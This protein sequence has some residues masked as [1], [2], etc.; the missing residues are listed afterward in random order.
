MI[1]DRFGKINF[2]MIFLAIFLCLVFFSFSDQLNQ[3]NYYFTAKAAGEY[4]INDFELD[5]TPQEHVYSATPIEFI[6]NIEYQGIPFYDFTVIYESE[7]YTSSDSPPTDA[8]EYVVSIVVNDSEPEISW[9]SSLTINPKPI[10]IEYAG[11]STYQYFGVEFSRNISPIGVID[12]EDIG[13]SYQYIGLRNELAENI[14]PVEAD[15]YEIVISISNSNYIITDYTGNDPGILL[16]TKANL[17]AKANDITINEG[18]EPDFSVA[19]TGFVNNE[20]VDDLISEPTVIFEETD[21]G[22][23]DIIPSGGA[24]DN[25]S[26]QYLEGI[27]TINKLS[28]SAISDDEL[29]DISISGVFHPDYSLIISSLSI[30]DE[31]YLEAMDIIVLRNMDTY[32][33]KP[34]YCFDTTQSQGSSSS[35]R[36]KIKISGVTLKEI[37]G[38][39]IL[40]VDNTG[41]VHEITKYNYLNGDLSFS[42]DSLG[43]IFIVERQ[44]RT[45]LTLG[46]LVGLTLVIIAFV[47]LTK[48]KYQ[49][50]K[51]DIERANQEIRD[52]KNK[53]RWD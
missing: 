40:V 13:L 53:Y 23:Y 8:A 34:I 11:T 18:E 37:F 38:Y 1:S 43:T 24:S 14:K 5:I 26:I 22:V 51:R 20:T 46:I 44:L 12:N 17:T 3:E 32:M 28:V 7:N 49:I 6:I 39:K 21:A 2:Y 30:D 50:E 25:Y 52:K 33:D 47:I 45:Y 15:S 42:S 36:Y 4:N 27:L 19:I 29:Y 35:S 48:L 16:I 41:L 31:K 9:V 10:T